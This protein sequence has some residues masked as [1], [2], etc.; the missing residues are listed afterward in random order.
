VQQPYVHIHHFNPKNLKLLV[1]A[2][3][4]KAEKVWTAERHLRKSF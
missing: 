4:F 3:G 2:S 1:E